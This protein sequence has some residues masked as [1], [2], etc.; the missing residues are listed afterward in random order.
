MNIKM[1]AHKV[2]VGGKLVAVSKLPT[3]PICGGHCACTKKVAETEC[4]GHL[5]MR[6][7]LPE[8]FR[9]PSNRK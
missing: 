9:N 7:N 2:Y 6:G 8:M 1:Q 4:V 5:G 3:C